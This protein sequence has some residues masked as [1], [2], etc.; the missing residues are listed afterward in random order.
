MSCWTAVWVPLPYRSLR[1]DFETLETDSF[2]P[3]SVVNYPNEED[4][5][6]ITEFKSSPDRPCPDGR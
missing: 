6:R 2:Q 5:T 1:L 4:F 3:A